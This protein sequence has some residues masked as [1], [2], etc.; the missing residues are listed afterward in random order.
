[1]IGIVTWVFVWAAVEKFFFDRTALQLPRVIL[2]SLVSADIISK[3]ETN[4]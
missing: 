4:K 3:E 1:M 2:L